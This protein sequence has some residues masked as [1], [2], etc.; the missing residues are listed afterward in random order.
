MMTAAGELTPALKAVAYRT[1]IG[2]LA[3]TGIRIGEALALDRED[4]WLEDGMLRLRVTKQQKQR[5][6]RCT[7]TT[8]DAL[9]NTPA[10]ATA[11]AR[12]RRPRRSSSVPAE[13]GSVAACST[14]RSVE[15]L[16]PG[17]NHSPA[18]SRR[19]VASMISAIRSP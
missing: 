6:C 1:I 18:P 10:S 9:G 7:T 17:A 2:L 12:G 16:G 4:V 5:M 14:R 11:R 19:T 8:S 13:H 3:V 15:L